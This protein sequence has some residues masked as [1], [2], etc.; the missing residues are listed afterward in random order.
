M[1]EKEHRA[2]PGVD[3]HPCGS[4]G[5]AIADEDVSPSAS[6]SHPS[7]TPRAHCSPQGT[8]A[9]L[10]ACGASKLDGMAAWGE[11]GSSVWKSIKEPCGGT[12]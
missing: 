3:E 2:R 1:A 5:T 10:G 4:T 9:G 12:Q 11:F 6:S 8:S 7:K